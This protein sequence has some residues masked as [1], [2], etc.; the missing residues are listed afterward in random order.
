MTTIDDL[1]H[2]INANPY[3]VCVVAKTGW[4]MGDRPLFP[5]MYQARE[6]ALCQRREGR[7]CW[8]ELNGNK[9]AE[10]AGVA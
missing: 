1:A 3:A 5:S 10:S 6:Y 8:I 7:E 9:V 2:L 4:G